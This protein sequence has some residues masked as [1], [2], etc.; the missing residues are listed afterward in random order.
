MKGHF[1]SYTVD[2]AGLG[3]DVSY[4]RNIGS[5][6]I[7]VP[8]MDQKF[9]FGVDGEVGYVHGIGRDVRVTD[10]FFL[11]GDKLRGFDDSGIGPRD[12]ATGDAIGGKMMAAG[13]VELR[14]P[15]FLP[16]SLGIG[17]SVFSDFGV[18]TD[19]D[20]KL[21]TLVD[22]GKLRATVGFGISWNS[23]LGPFRVDFAEPILEEGFDVT[24]SFRI[25]IGTS[26]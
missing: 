8:F 12:L 9:V 6:G 15:N 10:N 11:G 7:F 14:F 3:G 26:F 25:S 5:A 16:K 1:L 24:E 2:F 13:T 22:T 19:P 17:T 4:V 20:Q 18:V 23:P 21:G